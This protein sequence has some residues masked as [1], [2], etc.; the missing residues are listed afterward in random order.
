[1][2]ICQGELDGNV[3]SCREFSVNW[4]RSELLGGGSQLRDYAAMY[5]VST[6]LFCLDV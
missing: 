3:R 4:S 6:I 5:K 2:Y 1:M